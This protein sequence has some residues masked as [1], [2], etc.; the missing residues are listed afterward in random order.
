MGKLSLFAISLD[1]PAGVYYAGSMI[2]GH[3]TVQLN[4]SMKMRGIRLNIEGKARVHWTERHREGRHRAHRAGH[5]HHVHR[6]GHV[7]GNSDFRH[8]YGD[9]QYFD[10]DILLHGIWPSQCSNT[11]EL[12]QGVHTFPFQLQLPAGLPSSFEGQHGHVRYVVSCK[13]DKPWKFDHKTKR[14][15]TIISILDLNSQPSY[16]QRLQAS[17]EKTLCCLCCQSGPITATFSLDRQD[18]VPG[19]A[20]G[21]HADISN[22]SSRSMDKSYV[23]LKMDLGL[24]EKTLFRLWIEPATSW[25]VANILNIPTQ[26]VINSITPPSYNECITGK[27]DIRDEDDDHTYGELNFAPAYTYYNWGHSPAPLPAP[28]PENED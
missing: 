20:I 14:P 21:L 26:T 23:D 18:Y 15:F 28:L 10:Q 24:P 2:Q 25:V 7:V 13:I 8:Y 12:H 11:T 1:N 22:G 5:R 9:E 6:P 4:E 27:V 17:A 19:E 16:M 3:V